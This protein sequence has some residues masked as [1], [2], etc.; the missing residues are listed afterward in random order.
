MLLLASMAGVSLLFPGVGWAHG[1]LIITSTGKSKPTSLSTAQLQQILTAELSAPPVT[2]GTSPSLLVGGGAPGFPL[3]LTSLTPAQV[4]VVDASHSKYANLSDSQALA[5]VQS[6]EGSL[7]STPDDAPARLPSGAQI[8]SYLGDYAARV[9]LPDGQRVALESLLP[10]AA[11]SASGTIAPVDLSLASSGGGFA[12]VNVPV[13]VQIPSHLGDGVG[14]ANGSLTLTPVDSS[15]DALSGA[16]G[17]ASADA[18]TYTNTQTD[19]DTVAKPL[20]NGFEVLGVLRS[21]ASPQE[22]Y[23]RLTLPAGESVQP[24]PQLLDAFDVVRAGKAIAVLM[25][26]DAHDALGNDIPVSMTV[27]GSILEVSLSESAST[28]YEY[29]ITVDPT[30]TDS[31]DDYES[32]A[33]WNFEDGSGTT[34]FTPIGPPSGMVTWDDGN[35]YT[36]GNTAYWTYVTQGYSWVWSAEADLYQSSGTHMESTVAIGY[37][38]SSGWQEAYPDGWHSG[39][40]STTLASCWDFDCDS[41]LGNSGEY[42]GTS[43]AQIAS[44]AYENGGTTY[45]LLASSTDVYIAQSESPTVNACA[46]ETGSSSWSNDPS[47]TYASFCASDPGTGISEVVLSS[48]EDSG[49]GGTYSGDCSTA[50]QCTETLDFG[51]PLSGLPDGDDTVDVTVYDAEGN[52]DTASEQVYIDTTSPS[53]STSWSP[54][55]TSLSGSSTATTIGDKPQTLTA[56]VSDASSGI[57]TV[58]ATI[59]GQLLVPS[60]S[61]SCSGSCNVTPSYAINGEDYGEGQHTI[62]INAWDR[63]GNEATTTTLTFDVHHA[64][65]ASVGPGSLNLESGEFGLDSTDVSIPGFGTNL[66]VSRDYE[67]RTGPAAGPLGP[68]WDLSVP[69]GQSEDDF[70][71]L[72]PQPGGDVTLTDDSGNHYTFTPAGGGKYTPPA[73]LND[74]TLSASSDQNGALAEFPTAASSAAPS[75]ITTGPDGNVWYVDQSAGKIGKIATSAGVY[76]DSSGNGL[77]A[78]AAGAV[79]SGQSGPFSGALAVGTG[80]ADSSSAASSITSSTAPIT[81]TSNWTLE[82]WINPSSSSQTGIAVYD[83]N[84]GGLGSSANG[85]GFGEFGGASDSAGHCLEG[86]YEGVAWLTTDW[87]SFTTDTWYYVVETNS[88]GTVKFYVNG[89]EVWS[90]SPRGPCSA[91]RNDDRRLQRS[92]L[93]WRRSLLRW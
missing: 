28:D 7:L 92:Q 86:L 54:G 16:A 31:E 47:N 17:V 49:W 41:D 44:Y 58:Q 56:T 20:A 26:P 32:D 25:A 9:V 42:P 36:E 14:F 70:A 13:P 66:T 51:Q 61:T 90:G 10:L 84:E 53:A 85:F 57:S 38:N 50:V 34:A 68:G 45:E 43:F 75:G 39:G 33:G 19:T 83:G 73:A 23:Y 46:L 60:G 18:V 79:A 93:R 78:N 35:T 52:E 72:T 87:C 76:T 71:S 59:D 6:T 22:L 74:V 55:K 12:P 69:S 80:G 40:Y 3:G 30:A 21:P 91:E 77:S 29:P 4:A 37:Q 24:D 48:P 65:E 62:T 67:S 64:A 27:T 2:G 1:S 63:A 81:A 15:G 11:K 8:T 89:S 5:A 82:G 88:G